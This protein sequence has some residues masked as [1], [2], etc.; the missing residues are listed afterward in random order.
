MNEELHYFAPGWIRSSRESIEVD[1][2]VYGATSAGLVAAIA[3]RSLRLSVVVLNP[4]RHRGGMTTGGL[5]F[6]DLGNK[7]AIGGLAREFYRKLGRVYGE[8]ETWKFEPSIAS[9]VFRDWQTAAGFDVLDGCYLDRVALSPSGRKGSRRS[10]SA[11][12]RT[13]EILLLGGLRVRAGAYI[14]ATYEGDLMA[15]AEVPF[16]T[17]REGNNTYGETANG[18]QLHTTHQFDC[19]V[20]PY[21][22]PGDPR[23]GLLPEILPDPDLA[24]LSLSEADIRGRN[25]SYDSAIQAYN[26]RICMT[27][28]PEQ[29]VP[30][31]KPDGYERNRYELAARWLACTSDD[32]FRK[33]DLVR[34][35][36]TDTNNHGAMSTDYIGGSYGWPTGD[37]E[38]REHI[39]GEHVR[40][41][42]GLHYFMAND[43]GVPEPVRRRYATWG[44]ARD[45]FGDTGH[46]PPQLYIRE[47]RRMLG[48]YVVTERDC[49]G[50]RACEDPVGMG[51]Y[52]MDSH[53]CRRLLS[54]GMVRNEGD[55]QQRLPGPYGISY[56][57]ILPPIGACTN[58]AVP[59]AVSASHIAFGSV[60]MEPVFMILGESA[61]VAAAIALE[62]EI[63]M[64]E[65]AYET[66][67]RELRNR[68]QVL[69]VASDQARNTGSENPE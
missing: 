49:T 30:F 13:T 45:E 68:A 53:N 60:R 31:P 7:A 46:W 34:P 35:H 2:C 16:T 61:A 18:F 47:A 43:H 22:I 52:Q 37:Y 64:R 66:L 69:S 41:Q 29:R 65:V 40:Y 6:T 59:V 32:V 25:G 27:D 10:S 17:G 51:A 67:S 55:V 50:Q 38:T 21:I 54:D 23:S 44:L 28:L 20:D 26:F 5:G 42:Q 48:D 12:P 36:K 63:P 11:G 9:G 14:D 62:R 24:V 56:R 15:A 33:F 58:L 8:P 57:S 39:F 3:A 1:V 19:P 4:G